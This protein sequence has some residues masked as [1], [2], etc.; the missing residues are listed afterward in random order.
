[1]VFHAK[2]IEMEPQSVYVLLGTDE[3][4]NRLAP[5]LESIPDIMAANFT[6]RHDGL[7]L[8]PPHV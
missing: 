2:F 1:M 3:T 6:G 8:G 5:V 7:E 4:E